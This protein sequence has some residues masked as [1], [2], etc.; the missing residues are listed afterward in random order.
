M[1]RSLICTTLLSFC[2]MGSGPAAAFDVSDQDRAGNRIEAF[3]A[4][5]AS[6]SDSAIHCSQDRRWCA[7][8]RS[9]AQAGTQLLEVFDQ[10][11]P[12]KDRATWRYELPKGDDQE[13]LDLWP[14]I[15]RMQTDGGP[16]HGKRSAMIGVVMHRQTSYSGGWAD[17]DHLVLIRI[18]AGPGSEATF[19]EMFTLPLEGSS[20]IRACFS[21]EDMEQRA[22]ACHDEYRFSATLA[23]HDAKVPAGLPEFTYETEATSFPGHVSRSADSLANAP[24]KESDLVTVTDEKCSYRR[25]LRFNRALGRYEPDSPLPDCSDFTEL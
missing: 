18:D 11:T 25:I 1:S 23:L 4:T 9:D 2:L 21:E 12:P 17:A 5:A 19:A 14:R 15:V 22:G 10:T 20:T 3:E 13:S 24:L 8:I 16:E 7:Q 6:A